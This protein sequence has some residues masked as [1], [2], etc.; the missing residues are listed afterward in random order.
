MSG[1]SSFFH[2][3]LLHVLPYFLSH[4][5]KPHAPPCFVY[6]GLP[7]FILAKRLLCLAPS[8]T[9]YATSVLGFFHSL[10]L[11]RF[12][13]DRLL[14]SFSSS[15]SL[16][17]YTRRRPSSR[18]TLASSG[19]L[20]LDLVSFLLSYRTHTLMDYLIRTPNHS[21]CIRHLGTRPS[22]LDDRFC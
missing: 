12:L 9:L 21:I 8:W 7:N 5:G 3:F 4:R 15:F 16:H 11:H 22:P 10:V 19:S 18:T 2:L 20:F 14:R 6:G 1:V 17:T 13:H